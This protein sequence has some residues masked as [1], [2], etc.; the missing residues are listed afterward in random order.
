MAPG[1]GWIAEKF[2]PNDKPYR[3]HATENVI[4]PRVDLSQEHPDWLQNIYNQYGTGSCVANATAGAY[5][6]LARKMNHTGDVGQ[7]PATMDDPSRL[8]IYYN[9]RLLPKLEQMHAGGQKVSD[10]PPQVKKDP[11]GGSENRYSFKGLNLYGVCAEQAWPFKA[12][13]P[14]DPSSKVEQV[15]ECPPDDAYSKAKASHAVEY[16]RLDPDHTVA[17]EEA[18][19]DEERKAV[20][21]V[22]LMQLKQCLS[23]GYP[24]VFGF[25]YYWED[26]PWEEHSDAEW[27]LPDASRSGRWPRRDRRLPFESVIAKV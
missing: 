18:L 17:V 21:V 15:N 11:K 14:E 13:D 5:R 1:T 25:W 23:E 4:K 24:V 2:D 16:C 8:F 22:T 26:L 19:T 7:L 27:E 9:A 10:K 20:G 6:F 12:V 3:S